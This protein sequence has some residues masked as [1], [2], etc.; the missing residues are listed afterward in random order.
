VV[1]LDLEMQ[2]KKPLRIVAI[3]SNDDTR[4]IERALNCG[5]DD[6]LVK[7]AARE[8]LWAML[9]GTETPARKREEDSQEKDPVKLD[10]DLRQTL[11]DFLR[12][13][14][15]ALDEL[16]H[17]LAA[18]DREKFRRL[19]HKLA[20]SFAL[21]GFKWAGAQC[22]ALQDAAAQGEP[23][24]LARRVTALRAHLDNVVIQ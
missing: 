6:Y 17:A 9:A 8:T 21:Y 19:A 22:R 1:L 18:G 11:P 7:P 24:D 16:P 15:E 13:R 4:S 12:S 10:A 23:A 5:C 20:G 14:R 2:R 3:S